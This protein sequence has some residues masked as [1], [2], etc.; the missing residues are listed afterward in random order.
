MFWV[1]FF[2]NFPKFNLLILI[3]ISGKTKN[4]GIISL[5][6]LFC[7]VTLSKVL[8]KLINNLSGASKVSP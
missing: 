6:S 2:C 4:S 3:N 1:F 8:F 5:K 7:E